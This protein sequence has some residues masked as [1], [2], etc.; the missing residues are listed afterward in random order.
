MFDGGSQRK[1]AD[2]ALLTAH[3]ILLMVLDLHKSHFRLENLE[4]PLRVCCD[5]I[6]AAWAK[7]DLSQPNK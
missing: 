7:G 5:D 2:S 6:F 4:Q 1:R 3:K